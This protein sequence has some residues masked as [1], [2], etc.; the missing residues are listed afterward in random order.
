VFTN[1]NTTL[2]LH[3]SKVNKPKLHPPLQTL[4]FPEANKSLHSRGFKLL[5][6]KGWFQ[7][8]AVP[9]ISSGGFKPSLIPPFQVA[10]VAPAQ[11]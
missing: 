9:A 6:S 1:E 5:P 11:P 7:T 4:H 2:L 3:N 10:V 8:I